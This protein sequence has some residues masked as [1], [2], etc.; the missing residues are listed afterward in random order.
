[1]TT[2]SV[3]STDHP[4]TAYDDKYV[5]A[6]GETKYFNTRYLTWNDKG[7]DGGLKVASVSGTSAAGV[8]LEIKSD[9]TVIYRPLAG[10]EGL[11][12]FDYTLID[13]NGS[14]DTGTI[15]MQVGNSTA[16]PPA[17]KPDPAPTGGSG[18]PVIAGDD[19]YAIA[20]GETKYFNTRHL[21]LNDKGEDGG[22]KVSAIDDV[23][24]SGAKL[25]KWADGTVVYRP[26]AGFEGIDRINYTVTD[27]DGSKDT[28]TVFIKVG[29]GTATPLPQQPE[30]E[31]PGP[32]EPAPGGSGNPVIAADDSYA[33]ARGETKYFNTRHLTLNDKGEDGGLK[34]SA[35]DDVAASGAKLEKWADGTV[36]YRPL[37]GFEGIDRINY[38]VTDAD[39]SKDTATVFIKVGN[40]TATPLPQQP[41]TEQPAPS[42]GSGHPVIAVDDNYAIGKGETKYFNTRHLMLNDKGEDGGLKVTAIELATASGAKIDTWADG[43]VVYKPAAGWEGTDKLT[44]TLTDADGSKDTATVFI[45]VGNGTSSGSADPAPTSPTSPNPGTPGSSITGTKGADTLNGTAGNDTINGG[46]GNDVLNGNGGNDVLIGGLGRDQLNGGDGNDTASYADAAGSITADLGTHV[47][48][49]AVRIM[50]MGDSHT[51]GLIGYNDQQSGGYRAKL[52]AKMSGSGIKFDFVGSQTSGPGDN[53]HEGYNGWQ[54]NQLNGIAPKVLADYKPDVLLLMSGS[55]DAKYDSVATMKSDLLKLL[56]TIKANAPD[57]QILLGTVPPSRS[58]NVANI[59]PAKLVEYNAWLPG[60]VASKAASG[61]KIK[62]VDNSNISVGDISPLGVDWGV[63]L[64]SGGYDKLAGNWFNALKSLG[65]EQNTIAANRDTLSGIENLTGSNQAD[66]LRGD[67]HANVLNGLGG[68]DQLW[69]GGGADIFLFQKGK[70]GADTILDFDRGGGDHLKTDYALADIKGWGTHTLTFDTATTAP[71]TVQSNHIWQ[72]SDLLFG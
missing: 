49:Q 67:G 69:G 41:G 38:T 43:T 70:G 27:A 22:L 25:E 6:K 51:Y 30:P 66:I 13:A 46:V 16:T 9:G 7:L 63:H 35:I 15:F 59:S 61:M 17:S 50:A 19:N 62:L 21:M 45:K 14:R 60:M 40:G 11:D 55:N 8:K 26:L 57:T 2:S 12:S 36:V 10:W 52:A 28:A 3:L 58:D 48:T 53:Q 64:T 56:D 34:V 31:Q 54:S 1:M 47:A 29:N 4:V 68:N 33:I 37:A 20:K 32:T 42:G 23:A 44:Y 5:I 39:G 24:A 72:Q 18:H 65:V 71:E